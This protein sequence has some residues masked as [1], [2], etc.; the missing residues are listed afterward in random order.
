MSV[1]LGINPSMTVKVKIAISRKRNRNAY[2][3]CGNF[4]KLIDVRVMDYL[5][6]KAA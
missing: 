4:E 1:I 6:S 5:Y 2:Q 3:H